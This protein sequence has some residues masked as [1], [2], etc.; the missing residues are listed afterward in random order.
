MHVLGLEDTYNSIEDKYYDFLDSLEEKGISLYSVIDPLEMKGIPTFPIALLLIFFIVSAIPGLLGGL[1]A[2]SQQTIIVQFSVQD[3]ETG[4]FLNEALI[5]LTGDSRVLG[6]VTGTDGIVEAE[7]PVGDFDVA[8]EREGYEPE[9]DFVNIG[10]DTKVVSFE[11]ERKAHSIVSL[12]GDNEVKICGGPYDDLNAFGTDVD[13][14]IDKRA[15]TG[16]TCPVYLSSAKTYRFSTS[17]KST[18]NMAYSTVADFIQ[19][20]RCISMAGF[21]ETK[22]QK[23]GR[24][25]LTVQA[26]DGKP[27][28]YA[29]VS[30]VI[31]GTQTAIDTKRT[32]EL[33][34][35][36]FEE[37]VG[38]PFSIFVPMQVG[39]S[40]Y[41]GIEVYEF[42]EA[43]QELNIT[44]RRSLNTTFI[45]RTGTGDIVDEVLVTAFDS[46][47]KF[48]GH[49][50][51]EY[52]R[53]IMP[54][55]EDEN[56]R[57]GFFK[58]GY[59]YQELE[60]K[61]N[62]SD[63]CKVGGLCFVTMAPA[64]ESEVGKVIVRTFIELE[65]GVLE[66]L[67]GV[68]LILTDFTSGDL[69]GYGIVAP[70]LDSP[71]PIT[72]PLT[73]SGTF[74]YV[75]P[76][77]SYCI[78][79]A[80]A[81]TP[82]RRVEC[83]GTVSL[84]G[85]ETVEVNISFKPE[86]FKLQFNVTLRDTNES[87][88]GA[89]VRLF[90]RGSPEAIENKTTG[91]NGSVSFDVLEFTTVRA[92][93]SYTDDEGEQYRAV[94]REFFMS[95][96]YYREIKLSV[97]DTFIHFLEFEEVANVYGKPTDT[98]GDTQKKV[99][100]GT[101]EDLA[102]GRCKNRIDQDGSLGDK[103]PRSCVFDPGTYEFV[104]EVG[105]QSDSQLERFNETVLRFLLDAYQFREGTTEAGGLTPLPTLIL[106]PAQ[107]DADRLQENILD[108]DQVNTSRLRI[109]TTSANFSVSG[110]MV[111]IVK[112]P[113]TV[114]RTFSG[115][116]PVALNYEATWLSASGT[117]I[118]ANDTVLFRA[119][120][121][122]WLLDRGLLLSSSRYVSVPSHIKNI[123]LVID[124]F[125][126][127]GT[128]KAKVSN[129]GGESLGVEEWNSIEDFDVV[130]FVSNTQ[131]ATDVQYVTVS[132]K[133]KNLTCDPQ[134][135]KD[136]CYSIDGAIET[137]VFDSNI[138]LANQ[139]TYD[140]F[141]GVDMKNDV[142]EC[143]E[144]GQTLFVK[145]SSSQ[146]VV[147]TDPGAVDFQC[148]NLP[149]D[150][151]QQLSPVGLTF[152]DTD[153]AELKVEVTDYSGANRSLT[154]LFANPLDTVQLESENVNISS[155]F[156]STLRSVG[157]LT[158]V[159]QNRLFRQN[160]EVRGFES[161]LATAGVEM[162]R[163]AESSNVFV[164]LNGSGKTVLLDFPFAI[165]GFKDVNLNLIGDLAE[166]TF[167]IRSNLTDAQ[168]RVPVDRRAYN[169]IVK[170]PSCPGFATSETEVDPK[171]EF[172]QIIDPA[173]FN[174]DAFLAAE[175]PLPYSE[176]SLLVY[177]CNFNETN[178]A[179]FQAINV[180]DQR[181]PVFFSSEATANSTVKGCIAK[182][183][184]ERLV[185]APKTEEEG[186]GYTHS[187]LLDKQQACSDT[188]FIIPSGSFKIGNTC[189]G[190]G[191]DANILINRD[192]GEQAGFNGC[193]DS[194][195]G[196]C[197][198]NHS[199]TVFARP[200]EPEVIDISMNVSFDL[201]YYNR[202]KN[203]NVKRHKEIRYDQ[204]PQFRLYPGPVILAASRIAGTPFVGLPLQKYSGIPLDADLWTDNVDCVTKHCTQEQLARS[205]ALGRDSNLVSECKYSTYG[206]RYQP[207][208][209]SADRVTCVAA[210]SDDEW[211]TFY[212]AGKE[213]V[214]GHGL[215]DVSGEIKKP[216]YEANDFTKFETGA[217]PK[218]YG[219]GRGAV[220]NVG[221]R[222]TSDI[223][224]LPAVPKIDIKNL[225]L[226]MPYYANRSSFDANILETLD[227]NHLTYIRRTQF[228]EP[229][230][231]LRMKSILE[232]M[233]G[234][235]DYYA[236]AVQR[237]ADAD[238]SSQFNRVVSLDICNPQQRRAGDA[239]EPFE[240]Y[241]GDGASSYDLLLPAIYPEI[242]PP[243]NDG[244]STRT[245]VHFVANSTPQLLE[246]IQRFNESVHGIRGALFIQT[247]QFNL[248]VL[249][250]GEDIIKVNMTG[251]DL[252]SSTVLQRFAQTQR[253]GET[254][255]Q[256]EIEFR[257]GSVADSLFI[258][259]DCAFKETCG[260]NNNL[261]LDLE[262][263]VIDR[264]NN[265][266]FGTDKQ[267]VS[268]V[269]KVNMLL[270]IPLEQDKPEEA[271]FKNKYVV[272]AESVTEAENLIKRFMGI[273]FND[274][275]KYVFAPIKTEAQTI[276]SMS[277]QVNVSRG[278]IVKD[279]PELTLS[280]LVKFIFDEDD[281]SD[282]KKESTFILRSYTRDDVRIGQGVSGE[283][284]GAIW[285][286]PENGVYSRFVNI[287]A[288]DCIIGNPINSVSPDFQ[289][290][291]D[292]NVPASDLGK[293][294]FASGGDSNVYGRN[295]ATYTGLALLTIS[296]STTRAAGQTYEVTID[297]VEREKLQRYT[298]SESTNYTINSVTGSDG[299]LW[300]FFNSTGLIDSSVMDLSSLNPDSFCLSQYQ[301]DVS[302]ASANRIAVGAQVETTKGL[303]VDSADGTI[304]ITDTTPSGTGKS[305]GFTASNY[306]TFA[307]DTV[308]S[309]EVTGDFF[310]KCATLG[311]GIA[312]KGGTVTFIAA[313]TATLGIY[314]LIC[315]GGAL[316][317]EGTIEAKQWEEGTARVVT[318]EYCRVNPGNGVFYTPTQENECLIPYGPSCGSEPASDNSCPTVPPRSPGAYC[319]QGFTKSSNGRVCC[320]V[321][322]PAASD[323]FCCPADRTYNPEQNRC[324][325]TNGFETANGN[326]VGSLSELGEQEKQPYYYTEYMK[327]GSTALA[328]GIFKGTAPLQQ[329]VTA[330]AETTETDVTA[331]T[332]AGTTN[333]VVL[334]P[335]PQ[336]TKSLIYV[337][338]DGSA[339]QQYNV[340]TY[341]KPTLGHLVETL[342]Y[343]TRNVDSDSYVT[344]R[345]GEIS[346]SSDW[347]NWALTKSRTSAFRRIEPDDVNL[348]MFLGSRFEDGW[349]TNKLEPL[350]IRD[351]FSRQN[352]GDYYI[353]V[354]PET[355]IAA[356]G[357]IERHPLVI[358]IN[359]ERMNSS[360]ANLFYAA[361]RND[362]PLRISFWTK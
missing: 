4:D 37:L 2:P 24:V 142:R 100:E 316:L 229:F 64:L 325:C 115:S 188:P 16:S 53:V 98:V 156:D 62:S 219:E 313:T 337:K 215:L 279:V 197:S 272:L 97:L 270:E 20:D 149:P 25:Y 342:G 328:T 224:P 269:P 320:P 144:G 45:M 290:V 262:A 60:V 13:Y 54:L 301:R 26:S 220:L 298:I 322:K 357:E 68:E 44:L 295:P 81:A 120:A 266:T 233:W 17:D 348:F 318:A 9:S 254:A 282:T 35:V 84:S 42:E 96:N 231:V 92:E 302:V 114:L 297:P 202:A 247:G 162:A 139:N 263:L 184:R 58:E 216:A 83:E 145:K 131:D 189:A 193:D 207:G 82:Q 346:G 167:S 339:S 107:F 174:V 235:A 201:E 33:G 87:V 133:N 136:V 163:P 332:P 292:Y 125:Y 236:G 59:M 226:L 239:C 211:T 170:S 34:A 176:R 56:Y 179:E 287:T 28:Q 206:N 154:Y 221:E 112:V 212:G 119:Q 158:T 242:I 153:E 209:P 255:S 74:T 256:L 175:K 29:S 15:C 314:P 76:G 49:F 85:G 271:L 126:Y 27:M 78:T 273:Q 157:S 94:S 127:D 21:G 240:Y 349:V 173:D 329:Q 194:T 204:P 311:V 223:S 283:W 340:D 165:V 208:S 12:V 344:D 123:N 228:V 304:L 166:L 89:Q 152:A 214:P 11:L 225:Q 281:D 159:V 31:P 218:V 241:L 138:T 323:G 243:V 359:S 151:S 330:V 41:N 260:G 284:Q 143:D 192:T 14:N 259:S 300:Q 257:P 79:A 222:F 230:I 250:P 1:F 50:L 321:D 66:Q 132:T 361:A 52:G 46:S 104:F 308:T 124:E 129:K 91:A 141:L 69:L 227:K 324:A 38:T 181:V 57:V 116:I 362:I 338:S 55:I 277:V 210:G 358:I 288:T 289:D 213:F 353:E 345:I 51:S 77:K 140:Y 185:L 327:D 249:T 253:G 146:F 265:I 303:P 264:L 30:I 106:G 48:S 86:R 333:G 118:D 217:D 18:L 293:I 336:A 299:L 137:F 352:A 32:N 200:G 40:P 160:F 99:F 43:P 356:T 135:S 113:V 108:N 111:Y 36:V 267:V 343:G 95:R 6:F 93:F 110:S 147:P 71:F 75:D 90:R 195:I 186:K 150:Y 72:D 310:D 315:G 164:R 180:L 360:D 183:P 252:T 196:T 278:L 274:E 305:C 23:T 276:R 248:Q 103:I 67:P 319:K 291:F 244:E 335:S 88:V 234:V 155:L 7:V 177:K 134:G 309:W 232:E 251:I 237:P 334:P 285:G 331:E 130:F 22:P 5:D 80:V 280:E 109:N 101:A 307:Q 122:E 3:K 199:F 294:N 8:I 354:I 172:Q 245:I 10:K 19:K 65:D 190:N 148:S 355:V 312:N 205:A 286:I 63:Q 128:L 326:C 61:A 121:G 296:R 102:Q 317:S 168:T 238:N 350:K 351:F 47:N 198:F 258:V 268:A 117:Q 39:I 203:L 306:C 182:R 169:V 341:V 191:C 246:L 161:V 178:V 261:N 171:T 347:Y 70:E 73:A 275:G 105:L 187:F